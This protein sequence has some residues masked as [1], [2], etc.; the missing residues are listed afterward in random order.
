MRHQVLLALAL[1]AALA[2]LGLVVVQRSTWGARVAGPAAYK[3]AASALDLGRLHSV[4][5]LVTSSLPPR[6]PVVRSVGGLFSALGAALRGAAAAPTGGPSSGGAR[7]G[8]ALLGVAAAAQA[9]GPSEGPGGTPPRFAAGASLLSRSLRLLEDG[10][11]SRRG[12]GAMSVLAA[13][14]PAPLM[15][16]VLDVTR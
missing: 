2:C 10:G 4:G 14:A 7:R 12:S 3:A 9:G 15:P 13:P 5:S 11:G 6:E 16:Q 1:A 8:T